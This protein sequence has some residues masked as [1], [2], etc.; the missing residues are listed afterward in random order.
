[1]TTTPS[2]ELRLLDQVR[3]ALRVRHYS[4]RTE[5]SY[6]GWIHRFVLFHGKRHPDKM[7]SRQVSAF[8]SDL[9]VRGKV[10][11]STQNQALSALLF[12]YRHVLHRDVD[13]FKNVVR[14]KAQPRLPVVLSRAEVRRF[15]DELRG[16]SRLVAELL[17]GSGMR[18]L[19][20]LRLRVKDIDFDRHWIIVRNG[21]GDKDRLTV[22]PESL[23]P[24]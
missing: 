15:L 20:G 9:A 6:V 13:D 19:E 23:E 14:A 22:L 7:G 1:M 11:P 4:G 5:K 16:T 12:L 21:K 2:G 24:G 3:S 10:S 18:L 17:Y 8:L